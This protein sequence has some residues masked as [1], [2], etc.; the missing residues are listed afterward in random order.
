MTNKEI[1]AHFD[2]LAKLMELHGE[3]PFKIR[4]YQNAYRTIRSLAEPLGEQSEEEIQAIKGVGK[5]IAAKVKE[6][7]RTGQMATL[8][9]YRD[10]TP[11]GVREM[12]AIKGFGPKKIRV[13]WQDL[14]AENAGRS[15]LCL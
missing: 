15:A 12:L 11:E 4:S 1:A 13:I 5:A 9:K 7:D 3:N 8:D 6:L 10:R 14:G 2:E